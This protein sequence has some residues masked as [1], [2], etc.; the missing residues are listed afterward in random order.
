MRPPD[1]LAK[2]RAKGAPHQ[3]KGGLDATARNRSD[4]GPEA[5]T[6]S[7]FLR[8]P[9]R[10]ERV[11]CILALDALEEAVQSSD[12]S[13]PALTRIFDAHQQLIELRAALFRHASTGHLPAR[14]SEVKFRLDFGL[15]G[16]VGKSEA[17]Q[18]GILL[19]EPVRRSQR[20][21]AKSQFAFAQRFGGL[22]APRPRRRGFR[23]P[24][25][26]APAMPDLP[27]L[28]PAWTRQ[29]RAWTLTRLR[30]KD[31][32]IHRLASRSRSV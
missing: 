27:G 20:E 9:G 28:A 25:L 19:S 32:P 15:V 26:A 30:K 31:G 16:N 12:L 4:G 6:F 11:L 5:E 18:I 2:S 3:A 17:S 13:E 1:G 14:L 22:R 10:R 24:H 7:F 29:G 8:K 23:L 21:I